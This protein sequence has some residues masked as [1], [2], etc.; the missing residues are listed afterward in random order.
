MTPS[1]SS[2][3]A[4]HDARRAGLPLLAL[5]AVLAVVFVPGTAAGSDTS[6]SSLPVAQGVHSSEPAAAR[7]VEARL[8]VVLQHRSGVLD[9]RFV[10]LAT[11]PVTVV[12]SVVLLLAC[13]VAVSHRCRTEGG[14]DRPAARAPPRLAVTY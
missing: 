9:Q 11:L 1:T 13:A 8:S 5:L 14:R 7:D 2:C 6:R 10:P 3:A 4:R 12:V